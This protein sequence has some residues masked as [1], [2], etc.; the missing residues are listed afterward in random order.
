MGSVTFISYVQRDAVCGL[1]AA[2]AASWV[3]G[4]SQRLLNLCFYRLC[5]RADGA[6]S[7]VGMEPSLKHLLGCERHPLEG[8]ARCT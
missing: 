2:S 3:G 6:V 4:M 8:N 1:G 5:L 7:A